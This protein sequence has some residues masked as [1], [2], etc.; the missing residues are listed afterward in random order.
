MRGEIYVKSR[1]GT[2]SHRN[3]KVPGMDAGM[4]LPLTAPGGR[5]HAGVVQGGQKLVGSKRFALPS[6]VSWASHL[7]VE[8]NPAGDSPSALRI[9]GFLHRYKPN[10]RTGRVDPDKKFALEIRAFE[11]MPAGRLRKY[12]GYFVAIHRGRIIDADRDD[13]GLA[14]RIERIASREGPIPIFRVPGSSVSTPVRT[15]RGSGL[16]KRGGS[17][18]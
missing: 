18:R 11:S 15:Y 8:L 17:R 16:T 9:G 4:I 10:A 2:E 5:P 14:A 13:F 3:A 12:R 6:K 7:H 1:S